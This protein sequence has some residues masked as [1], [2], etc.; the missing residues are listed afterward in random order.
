MAKKTKGAKKQHL[1]LNMSDGMKE[2]YAQ[3]I[4]DALNAMEGAEWKKPWISPHSEWPRNIYG[5]KAYRGINLFM[6]TMLMEYRGWELPYFITKKAMA[7]EDGTKKYKGLT[8]NATLMLDENGYAV[9]DDKGMPKMNVEK[10]FPVILFKPYRK[11]ADGNEVKDEDYEQMTDDERKDC[12]TFWYQT[13]YLVY[14][15]EQTNFAT[16]YPDDY[17]KMTVVPEHEYKRGERDEVLERMIMQGEWRC[18]IR[19]GGV[20]SCYHVGDDFISLPKRENFLGDAVFYQVA[21]HEMAHS[22]APELKRDV[23]H[24]FGS[25]DYA[26]E[27]LVAEITS[28]IVCSMLGIGKLLDPQHI[29]YVQNW[30]QALRDN[31]DFMPVVMDHVHRA[32]NY[33]LKVYDEVAQKSEVK[34]L[35]AA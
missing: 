26:T 20:K 13:A 7:N 33:F 6:L 22:T 14:N 35:T 10:R 28:A 29:A 1:G 12:H 31:K 18:P 27:E 9:L 34:L 5:S 24:V 4:G 17:Q 23:A 32:V 15:L 11:D 16:L 2:K 3:L 30:R 19:F 25:A 21:I 8:A